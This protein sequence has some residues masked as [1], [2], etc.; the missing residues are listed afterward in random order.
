MTKTRMRKLTTKPMKYHFLII[1]LAL[2]SHSHWAIR[3]LYILSITTPFARHLP[4]GLREPLLIAKRTKH[5]MTTNSVTALRTNS[6]LHAWLGRH[7]DRA[8][9]AAFT[10]HRPHHTPCV[11]NVILGLMLTEAITPI[12]IATSSHITN[13]TANRL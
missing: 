11:G 2:I 7:I 4:N 1:L 6:R 3:S 5:L 9:F 8:R 13:A 12:A 10:D